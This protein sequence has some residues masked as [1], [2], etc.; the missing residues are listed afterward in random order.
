MCAF[1]QQASW[2]WGGERIKKGEHGRIENVE[3]VMG[4]AKQ[5]GAGGRELK[6]VPHALA[7]G[8]LARLGN[9]IKGIESNAKWLYNNS[10]P[11]SKT[12][13]Y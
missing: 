5:P 6:D 2:R 4:S 11:F 12:H 3:I 8:S 13:N 9:M 10:D 7:H 1:S